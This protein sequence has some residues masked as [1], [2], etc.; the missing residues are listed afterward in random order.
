MVDSLFVKE[1]ASS[2]IY[3]II[4]TSSFFLPSDKD[5]FKESRIDKKLDSMKSIETIGRSFPE[6]RFFIIC[7]HIST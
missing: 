4:C 5:G 3:L 1:F 2:L 6:P 7:G